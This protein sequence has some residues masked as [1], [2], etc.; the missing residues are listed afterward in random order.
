MAPDVEMMRRWATRERWP[1]AVEAL[2]PSFA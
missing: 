1:A 2:L